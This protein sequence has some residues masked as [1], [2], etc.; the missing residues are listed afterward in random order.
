MTLSES[1]TSYQYISNGNEGLRHHGYESAGGTWS[2]P[3][4]V[5]NE[6]KYIINNLEFTHKEM[7]NIIF[8]RMDDITWQ[9]EPLI[10]IQYPFSLGD[11]WTYRNED[12]PWRMDRLVTKNNKEEFTIQTL[13]DID[14]DL[15]WDDYMK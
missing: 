7:I 11:Q 13:Y 12:F 6:K 9:D 8:Q 1:F 5:N 2:F 4:L 14:N 10:S 15:F 3:R